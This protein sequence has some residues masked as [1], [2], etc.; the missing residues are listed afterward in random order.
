M[1]LSDFRIKDYDKE[2]LGTIFKRLNFKSFIQKLDLPATT[3]TI[4]KIQA[5]LKTI[6]ENKLLDKLKDTT[7]ISYI[8]DKSEYGCNIYLTLNNVEVFCVEN[9]SDAGLSFIFENSSLLKCGFKVKEDILFLSEKNI[10]FNGLG[11]DVMIAAYLAEPTRSSYDLE[12][13]TITYLSQELPE[14]TDNTD[15]DGQIAMVFSGENTA[16]KQSIADRVIALSSL[17][18]FFADIIEENGQHRLYYDIELPLIEVLADMQKTGVYVDK[19][20]LRKFGDDLAERIAIIKSEIYELS[21]E[22][23]NINSPKQLGEILFGKLGL[24]GGKKNKNGFSTNVDVLNKLAENYP[25]AVKV[26]EFRHLSKLQSTYVEGLLPMINPKTGRIHSNFNQTV[27]ATGRISSTEPNLQNIPVRT[28]LGREIRKMFIAEAQDS[29]LVDADYSQIELRVLAHISDD[30]TMKNAFLQ[31]LDIHTQTASQVFGTPMNEVTPVMRF[32]AKA[33]NFGIVYGIGA[34]SLAEDLKIPI[35]EADA[36]I[37]GYLKHYPNVDAYMKNSVAS[38]RENGYITTLL[39]RRRN[40]P[41]LKASNHNTQAFGERVAMNAPIQ[42]SAADIIKIAMVEVYNRLKAEGLKSK[43]ILQVHDELIVEATC[44]E[45]DQV[46]RIVKEEM[47]NA[48]KLNVP[49]VVDMNT[50]KSWFDTK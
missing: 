39:G 25:I 41:E 9:I 47:E 15:D 31:E 27:T 5:E 46:T 21:G 24:P 38:A 17:W 32:R 4:N 33:V 3:S 48:Y 26:L 22:E 44:D 10:A 29:C 20:A 1:N 34:F 50:G 14:T 2:A 23:F 16:P 35:K 11:F 6:P 19:D 18:K 36:Y 12:T 42:G 28:E 40:M 37:K 49:L 8:L 13:L 30:D 45:V 43:L 7:A